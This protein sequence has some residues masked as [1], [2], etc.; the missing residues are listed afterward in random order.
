MLQ[1]TV[2]DGANPKEAVPYRRQTPPTMNN[3]ISAQQASMQLTLSS[4]TRPR[5]LHL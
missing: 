3:E 5:G 1:G 4:I 2:A